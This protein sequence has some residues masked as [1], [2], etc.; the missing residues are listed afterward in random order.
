MCTHRDAVA[1][2]AVKLN[3][4]SILTD[5]KAFGIRLLSVFLFRHPWNGLIEGGQGVIDSRY[6][7][8]E[9]AFTRVLRRENT[10]Q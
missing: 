10:P 7:I 6:G 5:T 8:G 9:H 3:T 2:N 4:R 1:G